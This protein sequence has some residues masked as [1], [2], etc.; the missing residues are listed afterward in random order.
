LRERVSGHPATFGGI[1]GN[2][3]LIVENAR[4]SDERLYSGRLVVVDT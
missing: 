1:G 4:R 3:E 2:T